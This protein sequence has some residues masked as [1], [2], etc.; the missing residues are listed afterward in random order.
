M[1]WWRR[2]GCATS[3][4]SPASSGIGS[5]HTSWCC[6]ATSGT[7]TPAIAPTL[8]PQMPAHS[9][10]R[11]HSIVAAIGLH[12]VHAAVADVEAG[13]G[14][15]A[16]ERDALRLR[17][18]RRAPRPGG[19]PSRCR[20]TARSSEPRIVDGSSSGI[21]SARLG[22]RE[23][24]GVLDAVASA[25]SPPAL[26]L[27][28]SA[29]AWWRSRCRRRRTS[30][31]RR[32]ARGSRTARRCPARSGTSCASRSSGRPGPAR[33][34]WSRRSRTAAPGRRRGRRCRRARRGGRRRSC[35]RCP[36]PTIT[37]RARSGNG[38]GLPSLTGRW[39]VRLLL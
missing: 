2:I 31:A 29:R 26:Q 23:Q 14:D 37:V 15:A 25:P 8:G 1:S 6:T 18:P 9:R 28:A 21:R 22:R 20:R 3:R 35:P 13:D 11:S 24:L 36:R 39:C 19:P 17:A 33:A 12:A 30:P 16:L 27:L 32:P 38:R 4:V 34:S 7:G 10:T 5:V